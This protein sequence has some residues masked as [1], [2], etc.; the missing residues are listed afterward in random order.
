MRGEHAHGGRLRSGV[1]WTLVA[2]ALGLALAPGAG[3]QTVG[4]P[5]SPIPTDPMASAPEYL[6]APASAKP[7]RAPRVPRHP[8]MARNGRSNLH[9]D[10]YMSDTYRQAGPLG[11]DPETLSTFFARECGSV[12]FDRR[13]RIVTVCVGLD[14]PVL[15]LLDPQTLETLAAMP[16]PVRDLSQG[17]PFTSFAGG[18]YFY[19]DHRD[20]AVVPTTSRHVY[21]VG[22]T[23]APDFELLGD[24]DLTEHVPQGDAIISALPDWKGRIWF[25]SVDG[26]VGWVGRRSGRV[27]SRQL[28][29]GITNSFS[30]DD[31][32]GVY[33]VTDTALYRLDARRGK[34]RRSWRREYDDSGIHKPGQSDAG[35]G[36]TPTVIGRR[37]V[38]ITDNADPMQVVVYRRARE[39]SGKRKVCE[40]PVFEPGAGATDQSLIGI[41]RSIVTE[42]NYGYS[43]VSATENGGVTEPGLQRVDI[44]RDRR[45]CHTVWRSEERAPSVVPKLSLGAGL[46]YTYTKPPDSDDE[47]PWYFTAIDF[48]TG[49]TVF[50]QLTGVGLG[51]N[52]N[53]APV[54]IGPDGTAY[55][56]ALGGL[57]RVGD[58]G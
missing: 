14:R 28:G 49:E 44:D 48:R 15:A 9:D 5:P 16:L 1:A 38:A 10:G 29:E 19:L 55:V 27:Q 58:G 45:G 56:G 32:G 11:E 26:V 53:Y 36:T 17:N 52:N 6:G 23:D 7:V 13:G 20:R 35:S 46:V 33:V 57:V 22:Q 51:H 43:G 40:E 8:F 3:A 24:H 41:R 34:V 30:V 4:L 50:K 18:G 54:S 25:A 21:V 42:N 2:L 12:T 37:Y 39:I 47:D 31:T